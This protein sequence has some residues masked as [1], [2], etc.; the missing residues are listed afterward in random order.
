MEQE[1]P[2]EHAAIS[3][4]FKLVFYLE[5]APANL[6]EACAMLRDASGHYVRQFKP[7]PCPP[8]LS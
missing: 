7:P 6:I 5:A 8:R 4:T 3:R 1:I 2:G